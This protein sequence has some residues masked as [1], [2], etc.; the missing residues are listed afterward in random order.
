MKPIRRPVTPRSPAGA[1]QPPPPRQ[2]ERNPAEP[3]RTAWTPDR[4]TIHWRSPEPTSEIWL[5][6]LSDRPR[7][8]RECAEWEAEP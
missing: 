7:A 2:P 4:L 8:E 1:R 6:S 3:T 5:R